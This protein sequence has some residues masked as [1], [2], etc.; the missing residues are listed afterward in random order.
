MIKFTIK[1]DAE[2]GLLLV[3]LILLWIAFVSFAPNTEKS[4]E[5]EQWLDNQPTQYQVGFD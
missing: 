1:K 2:F 4:C 5:T 3:G